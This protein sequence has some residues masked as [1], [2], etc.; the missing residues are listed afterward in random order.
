L[1]S[2]LVVAGILVASCAYTGLSRKSASWVSTPANV[3]TANAWDLPARPWGQYSGDRSRDG[4]SR[5]ARILSATVS[6]D[7]PSRRPHLT[8][9]VDP[10][11][12]VRLV[13]GVYG[14]GAGEA[15]SSG[16]GYQRGWASGDLFTP[17]GRVIS[18]PHDD[19]EQPQ[20]VSVEIELPSGADLP[21]FQVSLFAESNVEIDRKMVVVPYQAPPRKW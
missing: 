11:I 1:L 6:R 12:H 16:S 5:V 21:G 2:A 19:R 3:V 20:E 10:G 18:V 13:V 15:A 9:T 17:V 14:V 8:V 7:K 4:N